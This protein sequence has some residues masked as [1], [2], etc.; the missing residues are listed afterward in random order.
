[1]EILYSSAEIWLSKWNDAVCAHSALLLQA[2]SYIM[3]GE[4]ECIV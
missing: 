4:F 3:I 1:M 2:W